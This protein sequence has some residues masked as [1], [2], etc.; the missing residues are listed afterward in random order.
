Y[1]LSVQNEPDAIVN[2]YE[3]CNWSAQQIHDFVPY[4]YNSLMASNVGSTRI[5][6]PESQNWLDYS[7]LAS[8]AMNDATVAANVSI[9]GDHNYDGSTGPGNLARNS[10]GKALW[11]T[12]VSLLSGS[13]GSIANGVYYAQRIYLFLTQA[14]VNAWHYW[15]LMTGNSTGN[16][17]L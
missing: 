12:E 4:L 2:S 3:S 17:G 9:I 6:L 5:M 14:Q 1:A 8:T 16:E 11:E 7:N 13:D 15:W 10:Y